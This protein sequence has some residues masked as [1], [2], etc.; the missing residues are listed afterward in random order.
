MTYVGS[1]S[2]CLGTTSFSIRNPS[3][4]TWYDYNANTA[5]FPWI[6]SFAETT[7]TT[8]KKTV[9]QIG[10]PVAGVSTLDPLKPSSTFIM[11]IEQKDNYGVI[12]LTHTWEVKFEDFCLKEPLIQV[13]DPFV[14]FDYIM[15]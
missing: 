3:D 12:Y 7:V 15:L 10:A 8:E 14:D 13:G 6:L 9:I 4:L 2:T 1:K 11:K 5:T